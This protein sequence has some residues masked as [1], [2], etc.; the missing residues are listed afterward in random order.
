MKTAPSLTGL[1]VNLFAL[2]AAHVAFAQTA[3]DGTAAS[4]TDGGHAKVLTIKQ[5]PPI[6]PTRLTV[7]SPAFKNGADIPFENTQ[8]RGNIFQG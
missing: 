3:A 1:A 5:V 2:A 6:T 7:T 8:Y 4:T